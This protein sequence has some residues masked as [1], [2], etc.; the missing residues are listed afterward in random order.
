MAQQGPNA[1]RRVRSL[2]GGIGSGLHYLVLLLLL[3]ALPAAASA[4]AECLGDETDPRR[5]ARGGG[6]GVAGSP[7]AET[8]HAAELVCWRGL[9]GSN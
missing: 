5:R 8:T 3:L 4:P 9:N 1:E 6:G 2:E 7:R